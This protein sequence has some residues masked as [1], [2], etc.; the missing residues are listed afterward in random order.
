[1]SV[2][3]VIDGGFEDE[4]VERAFGEDVAFES[5]S[6]RCG[7][8]GA[9]SCVYELKRAA[10]E[11]FR[12]IFFERIAP[13]FH[14]GD[15]PPEEGDADS[16][17]LLSFLQ[18]V[19][20]ATSE[21]VVVVAVGCRTVFTF[22]SWG[23]LDLEG[24]AQSICDRIG[25]AEAM[26][27][28]VGEGAFEEGDL[29]SKGG[30]AL[31]DEKN[32]FLRGDDFIC[33]TAEGD[34]VDACFG[35]GFEVI[36]RIASVFYRLRFIGEIVSGE[37]ALP[38]SGGPFSGAFSAR[39]TLEVADGV[40]SVDGGDIFRAACGPVEREETAAAESCKHGFFPERERFCDGGVEGVHG[41]K[42]EWSAVEVLDV[43]VGDVESSTQ[44]FG[45]D[46]WF[47][48]KEF[49]APVPRVS[50]ERF[51]REHQQRVAVCGFEVDAAK[52]LKVGFF[53]NLELGL[54][55]CLRLCKVDGENGESREEEEKGQFHGRQLWFCGDGD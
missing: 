14:S 19:G 28:M 15:G 26:G 38:V 17:L 1:M 9:D 30:V 3:G 51:F 32:V 20:E 43:D 33:A 22:R 23:N 52:A 21:G 11:A 16:S 36:H 13:A 49:S 42:G 5:E 47:V 25:V 6:V 7:T 27:V 4:K 39:P 45:V 40:V 10:W 50:G 35:E 31:V 18:E 29:A 34:D 2:G 12:E 44:E 37:K 41:I 55:L 48:S 8:E 46:L 53:E 54:G 24:I